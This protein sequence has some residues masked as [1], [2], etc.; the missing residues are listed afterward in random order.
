MKR[1]K[2]SSTLNLERNGLIHLIGIGGTGMCGL[3]GCLIQRGYKVTGSDMQAS[4]AL[5]ALKAKGIK[6]HIGH[7]SKNINRRCCLVV[8]SAA[9]TNTNPEIIRAKEFNIPI[10][11]YAQM[12]GLLMREKYGIAVAGCHGKTTTS[13]LLAYTLSHAGEKPSFVI[14]GYVTDLKASAHVDKGD[15]FVSEACEYD[16]SFHSLF[17][18]IA[19]ITNIEA[20]H[21]DYYKNLSNII[22][23]FRFFA[24]RVPN[25]G[26][27]IA[28]GDDKNTGK[29]IAGLKRKIISFGLSEKC[30]WRATD[31]KLKN[32]KWY[33]KALYHK[34]PYSRFSL[35]I[36][37][38]HNIYNALAVLAVTHHLK[39]NKNRVR[40]ALDK[41]SG[42]GRRFQYHGAFNGALVI[43]DYG[44]HP[45][46]IKATLNAARGL[47]PDKQICLVFQPHQA[48]R[49]RCLINEFTDVLSKADK[50]ILPD[51]YF[52][53]DSEAEKKRVSSKL[54]SEKINQKGGNAYYIP[55]FPEIIKHLR[56]HLTKHDA[57]ITMGAGDVWKIAVELTK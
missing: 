6:V 11:K 34:K 24:G 2:D 5:Q 42:V 39:L 12:V 31:I 20:D 17:Y 19:V 23:S 38:I 43:D 3:A 10:L 26:I 57:V 50:V 49:T 7:A 53:R 33:F 54:L 15:F 27:I 1:L 56:N 13:S 32:G 46:E 48:H 51:I 41:F 14:G 45:T 16:R 29:A 8:K 55:K 40:Q 25:D 30:D 44:H 21:L 52:A 36:Q 37:G 22:K 9:I 4:P 28:N 35:H 18:K 47:Y